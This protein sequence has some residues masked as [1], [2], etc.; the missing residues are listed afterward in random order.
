MD[1]ATNQTLNQATRQPGNQATRQPG[2]DL[3]L[4]ADT[5]I[6]SHGN[7]SEIYAAVR[8]VYLQVLR[9]SLVNYQPI[10]AP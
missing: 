9:F 4:T 3:F 6:R 7:P 5:Q 8:Q 1:R 2:R 10:N